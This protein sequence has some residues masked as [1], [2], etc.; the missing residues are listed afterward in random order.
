M[1]TFKKRIVPL[2]A[3][4]KAEALAAVAPIVADP[5]SLVPDLGARQD[6]ADAPLGHAPEPL[7][8]AA[9]TGGS[10]QPIWQSTI[11]AVVHV[12]LE[13][14]K[15]NP[16]NPRAVY[17]STAVDEMAVSLAR[18]GQRV[19]ALGF[20]DDDGYCVLIEGETRLRGAR[21]AGLDTLRVELRPRPASDRE[22]YEMARAANV[23]RRDQSP[24]DDALR[25][26]ELLTKKVYPT[27]VALAKALNVGEDQVSRILSLSTL[28]HRL[29]LAASETRALLGLRMLNALREF[30][31]VQGEDATLALIQ[32]AD[33]TGMGYRDV[34]ARRKAAEKGPVTRARSIREKLA[35]K[36]ATGEIRTF[37]HD[38]RIE[39][40]LK[41][42]NPEDLQAISAQ[43]RG[44]FRST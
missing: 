16:L 12:P 18:D 40:V 32:E 13:K 5:R 39:L 6:L 24:L 25:W 35:F 36:N 19:A 3:V 14:I 20:L 7:A 4:A 30:Y 31:E 44:L 38:G 26:R 34:I 15:S 2:E 17:T 11:G 42:L 10:S 8:M 37:E 43:I 22:L 41:D 21:A 23:E 28:P 1:A 27:Q 9:S 33:K 29:V